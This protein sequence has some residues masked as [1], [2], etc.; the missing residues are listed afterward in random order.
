MNSL[1]RFFII[2]SQ[3][4]Y[5][6]I[7]F[8]AWERCTAKGWNFS[9]ECLTSKKACSALNEYLRTHPGL[10]EEIEKR[11]GT[12]HGL[13]DEDA[14]ENDCHDDTDVPSSAVIRDQLGITITD[15]TAH[16]QVSDCVVQ[17]CKKMEHGGLVAD[18]EIEDMWAWKNGERLR[19]APMDDD[20]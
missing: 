4:D 18:G 8:Q 3:V 5:H 20:E 9:G 7:I 12:V 17:V 15:A 13:E 2:N 10:R 11:T 1:R 19:E 16:D 6:S 14:Q